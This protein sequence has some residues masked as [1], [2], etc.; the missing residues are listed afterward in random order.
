MADANEVRRIEAALRDLGWA[1]HVSLAEALRCWARLSEE[2]NRYTATVDDYTNDLCARDYLAEVASRA[3]SHLRTAI[4][5]Q[6]ATA[7]V[8]FRQSTVEDIDGRLGRY[9]QIQREDGWW[10]H[11]RPSSG[12]LADYLAD[13]Q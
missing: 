4:E 1:D 5:D 3:S 10:W 13:A 7:D 12:P 11:R 8:S 6:L 2:V 9:A